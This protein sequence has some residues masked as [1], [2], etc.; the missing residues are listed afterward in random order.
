MAG[1]AADIR[2]NDFRNVVVLEGQ[3]IGSRVGMHRSLT[4][5]LG[6]ERQHQLRR[7]CVAWMSVLPDR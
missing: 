5:G 2:S 7:F 6:R 1:A 3:G 4:T